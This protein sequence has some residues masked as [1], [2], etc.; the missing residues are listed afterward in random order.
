MVFQF[1]HQDNVSFS[2][3][4]FDFFS[5]FSHSNTIHMLNHSVRFTSSKANLPPAKGEEQN[6]T[7]GGFETTLS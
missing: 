5:L 1:F 4:F 3:P 6:T 7:L 2:P